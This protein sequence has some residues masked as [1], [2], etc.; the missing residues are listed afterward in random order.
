MA[1]LGSGRT[2]RA[3]ALALAPRGGWH[4]PHGSD[5]G[6]ACTRAALLPPLAGQGPRQRSAAAWGRSGGSR[7]RTERARS[8]TECGMAG[9]YE[10]HD[11]PWRFAGKFT[12]R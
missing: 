2:Q 1:G 11:R 5:G 10:E 3:R 8:W 7:L 4:G 12:G 6:G 9:D